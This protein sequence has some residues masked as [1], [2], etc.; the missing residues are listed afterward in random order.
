MG[1]TFFQKPTIETH[2]TTK[3][4]TY[5]PT[6]PLSGRRKTRTSLDAEKIKIIFKFTLT[7]LDFSDSITLSSLN[8]I[9]GA[10]FDTKALAN[11]AGEEYFDGVNY[12]SMDFF[13]HEIQQYRD[14][15][16]QQPIV[17]INYNNDWH[18]CVLNIETFEKSSK[19]RYF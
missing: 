11:K 13:A 19:F 5:P 9:F 18:Q 17:Y 16:E 3:I 12:L 4:F 1:N 6:P 8:T 14:Q 10:I 2:K 15:L 7:Y